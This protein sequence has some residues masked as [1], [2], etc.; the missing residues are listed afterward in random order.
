MSHIFGGNKVGQNLSRSFPTKN[1]FFSA[2]NIIGNQFLC[3][4]TIPSTTN[5]LKA[6]VVRVNLGYLGTHFVH[7]V[8]CQIFVT[9]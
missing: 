2:Q 9:S 5:S 7:L 6:I 8:T 3:C 4:I 1:R